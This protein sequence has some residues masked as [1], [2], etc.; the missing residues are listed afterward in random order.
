ML[1]IPQE[2]EKAPRIELQEGRLRGY[3]IQP[4]AKVP[5]DAVGL[6]G[7]GKDPPKRPLHRRGGHPQRLQEI[8]KK[9]LQW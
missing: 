8:P 2:Q 7:G 6:P 5:M 9:R 1:A 3:W 4:K